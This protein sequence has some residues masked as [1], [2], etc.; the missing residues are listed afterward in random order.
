[1]TEKR[2]ARANGMT[3]KVLAVVLLQ[4]QKA[5]RKKEGR[6][7]KS[8]GTGTGERESFNAPPHLPAK[9]EKGVCGQLA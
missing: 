2:L 9:R 4:F 7:K 5:F 8:R 1:M 3:F 6:G